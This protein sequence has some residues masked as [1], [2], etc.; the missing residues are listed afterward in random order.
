MVEIIDTASLTFH[1]MI[2]FSLKDNVVVTFKSSFNAK[3]ELYFCLIFSAETMHQY[4]YN[5][6]IVLPFAHAILHANV[7]YEHSCCIGTNCKLY[8]MGV[9]TVQI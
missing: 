4:G 9:G 1:F 2:I 8:L 3:P 7:S 6:G 5:E